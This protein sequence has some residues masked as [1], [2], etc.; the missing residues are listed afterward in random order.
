MEAGKCTDCHL[1][2]GSA[3]P[4]LLVQAA[5]GL[6][7]ECHDDKNVD[8]D[9]NEWGTAHPPVEEGGC[10]DCHSPHGSAEPAL[11][12][13][14]VPALCEECHENMM[15]NDFGIEW[16]FP[17]PPVMEGEC[18]NCHQPHG[19]AAEALLLERTNSL[20]A[21]CHED[22]HD[23]HLSRLDAEKVEIAPD[24]PVTKQGLLVCTGCHAP[25]G[26]NY[27]F[28]WKGLEGELCIQCHRY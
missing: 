18:L 19:S 10:T 24:F 22:F 25:H 16:E 6:C 21:Q 23:V 13:Q 4:A 11:L 2:H 14:S 7:N 27:G 3:E 1:P 26:S 28:L 12:V 20:C 9:G 15:L 17:H 8:D 5:P